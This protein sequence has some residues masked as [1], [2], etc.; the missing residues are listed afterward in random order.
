MPRRR[1]PKPEEVSVSTEKEPVEV[2][3]S[4]LT[5]TRS[6]DY[7][8]IYANQVQIGI[9]PYD[10]HLMFNRASGAGGDYPTN[11]AQVTIFLS[12]H[13]AKAFQTILNRVLEDFEE[14]NGPITPAPPP[15][16]TAQ[17]KASRKA[18]K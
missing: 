18:A 7:R 16:L 13:Q 9:T 14:K 5:Q 6:P 15:H 3:M 1:L 10:L 17:A 4:E 8:D 12:L 11:Q 2:A